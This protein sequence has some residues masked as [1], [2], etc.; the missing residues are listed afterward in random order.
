M[1][2]EAGEVSEE[3]SGI[4]IS[5]VSSTYHVPKSKAGAL[6]LSFPLTKGII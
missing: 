2:E 5:A 6:G 1:L 3:L 4:Q